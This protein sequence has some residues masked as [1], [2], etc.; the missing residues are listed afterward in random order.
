MLIAWLQR[1]CRLHSDCSWCT[2]FMHSASYRFR[3]KREQFKQNRKCKRHQVS[4]LNF[5]NSGRY[6]YFDGGKIIRRIAVAR[7]KFQIDQRQRRASHIHEIRRMFFELIFGVRR[8]ISSQSF[9][10]I[11]LS[12]QF[13]FFGHFFRFCF[14]LAKIMLISFSCVYTRTITSTCYASCT[15]L[16]FYTK[17]TF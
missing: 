12:F 3:R 13:L 14:K 1:F 7:I 2:C 10:F 4:I 6:H 8:T 17:F 16:T 15:M 9:Q 5:S 11:L